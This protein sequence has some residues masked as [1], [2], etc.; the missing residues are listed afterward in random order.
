M[1]NQVL[2]TCACAKKPQNTLCT[3]GLFAQRK[4]IP[5][6]GSLERLDTQLA[7]TSWA[8][9]VSKTGWHR[10]E[11]S[12][13][14]C[15]CTCARVQVAPPAPR[16]SAAHSPPAHS[17][18]TVRSP[19]LLHSRLASPLCR[20]CRAAPVSTCVLPGLSFPGEALPPVWELPWEPGEKEAPGPNR[21]EPDAES[22]QRLASGAHV[23]HPTGVGLSGPR[24]EL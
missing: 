4:N 11:T 3:K 5:S 12:S 8:G 16:Q 21:A 24:R 14:A 20:S 17:P 18:L 2:P 13:R 9:L 22:Q 15:L 1:F 19:P 23:H 10:R 7:R 6:G